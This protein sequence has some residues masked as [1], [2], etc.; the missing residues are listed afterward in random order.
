MFFYAGVSNDA[1]FGSTLVKCACDQNTGYTGIACNE[2]K[3]P[4]NSLGITCSGNGWPLAGFGY[5]P[6]STS[7]VT[8]KG[9]VAATINCATSTTK[10]AQT[11]I[12]IPNGRIG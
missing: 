1:V 11:N 3:C 7:P 6:N 2:G 4:A 12:C 8:A 9:D 10:C 5:D